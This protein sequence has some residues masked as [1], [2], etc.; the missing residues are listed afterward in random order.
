MSRCE[1]DSDNSSVISGDASEFFDFEPDHP[2]SS[3]ISSPCSSVVGD[4]FHYPHSFD[5]KV[6]GIRYMLPLKDR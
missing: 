2:S 5:W 1:M 6:S 4:E 3:G